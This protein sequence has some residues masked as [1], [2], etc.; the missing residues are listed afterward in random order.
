[1]HRSPRDKTPGELA[2]LLSTLGAAYEAYASIVADNGV[3]GALLFSLSSKEEIS[4]T[5]VD[6][7]ITNKIH[8]RVLTSRILEAIEAGAAA[9]P[10]TVI[11]SPSSS[12]ASE[13]GISAKSSKEEETS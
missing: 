9:A 12:S 3:D 7:G 8:W 13:L 11:A 2:A 4:E 6:L 1:M 10:N 5:L